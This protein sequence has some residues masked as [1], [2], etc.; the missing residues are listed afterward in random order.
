MSTHHGFGAPVLLG[1]RGTRMQL[2]AW[3]K[4]CDSALGRLVLFGE[5]LSRTDLAKLG[6][7]EAA[8]P[9]ALA[10]FVAFSRTAQ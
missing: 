7:G 2:D 8:D 3:R 5:R 1:R 9:K 6:F 4:R 10:R